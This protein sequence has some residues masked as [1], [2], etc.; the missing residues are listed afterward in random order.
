MAIE[1]TV[2][3][4]F[5]AG[6]ALLSFVSLTASQI[7]KVVGQIGTALSVVMWAW[8][9]ISATDVAVTTGCCTVV[10]SYDGLA[11]FGLLLAAIMFLFLV[12]SVW[13]VLGMSGERA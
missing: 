6:I 9:S 13:N 1:Q 2:W 5:G 8:W 3:L 11:I 10:R 7:P 4:G 12:D